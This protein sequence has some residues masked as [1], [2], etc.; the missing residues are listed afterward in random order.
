MGNATREKRRE[1]KSITESSTFEPLSANFFHPDQGPLREVA[2][3]YWFSLESHPVIMDAN[4]KY[5]LP[6]FSMA[7]ASTRLP[8]SSFHEK[9]SVVGLVKS[10]ES[11]TIRRPYFR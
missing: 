7:G 4:I 2:V 3:V 6:S 10:S 5:V 9:T 8:P 1:R 11:A